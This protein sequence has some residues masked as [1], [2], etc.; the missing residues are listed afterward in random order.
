MI[1][2]DKGLLGGGQLGDVIERHKKYGEF[3]DRLDIV[4]FSKKGFTEYKISD[5]V[6]AYP[7]NSD[8]KIKYCFDALR[9]GKQL[10]K[11]NNYDLIVTQT[12]FIDGLVGLMLKNKFNAK[13]LV[14][15]HGDFW[16]NK[17]WLHENK[18]NYLFLPI[19]KFVVKRADAIRV[20]SEGQAHKITKT[21]KQLVRVISTPVD[22]EKYHENT[23]VSQQ[24]WI[25]GGA[26]T[27]KQ[28]NIK[29]ILHVG[30]DDEVKDYGTLIRAFKIVKEKIPEA[31]FWQAGADK[32]IKEAMA[33]NCFSDVE[34]R[35]L[36]SADD[37]ISLYYQCSLVVLSST[38]ESFGKV[39]VEAN[40]CSKPVV[41]TATTGAREIIEDGENGFL[42]PIG[43]AE[44]LAEK[45]I[46]LLE[47]PEEIKKMGE[48]GRELMKEK[49][50]D[51]TEKIIKFWDDII[52]NRL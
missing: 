13:L 5:K 46:W 9:I 45:I 33:A 29:I 44:K 24:N 35:G 3:C 47:H 16:G 26:K 20:M 18:L 6:A 42:V 11:K 2:I 40:A 34:L 31:I 41:S 30:R 1:S 23:P 8:Y 32:K 27:Q 12:P 10:F 17:S 51:N 21:Q 39:L 19:S 7:T 15:F 48:S 37:M 25:R 49:Y 52:N 38:S 50:G 43:D 22:L 36:V 14:H 4:I 28:E